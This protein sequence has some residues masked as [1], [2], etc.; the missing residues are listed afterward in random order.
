MA[1]FKFRWPGQKQQDNKS[2]KSARPARTESID[3][4][5]RRA[6][7]R[8]M[9]AAVLIVLG[10]VGAIPPAGKAMRMPVV[11]AIKAV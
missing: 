11:D 7:H 8:L 5:R 2:G 9:G 1:F 4:M 3:A 6:R 10:V